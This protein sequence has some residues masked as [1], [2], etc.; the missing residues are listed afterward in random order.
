MNR[1]PD[2]SD[3]HSLTQGIEYCRVDYQKNLDADQT[4]NLRIQIFG[5]SRTHVQRSWEQVTEHAIVPTITDCLG[6]GWQ[7]IT[8]QQFSEWS[9]AY[10][11]RPQRSQDSHHNHTLKTKNPTLSV[12]NTLSQTASA[13]ATAGFIVGSVITLGNTVFGNRL[14]T[15]AKTHLTQSLAEADTTMVKALSTVMHG[16]FVQAPERLPDAFT[17]AIEVAE[18]AVLDGRIAESE[19]EWRDLARRWW[20]ASQLMA[21]IPSTDTRYAIAQDRIAFYQQNSAEA[22]LE[23]AQYSV[24]L[25]IDEQLN[26]FQQQVIRPDQHNPNTANS[27]TEQ[28]KTVDEKQGIGICQKPISEIIYP[29]LSPAQYKGSQWGIHIESLL[30]SDILYSYNSDKFFIPASNIK[31]FTTAAAFQMAQSQPTDDIQTLIRNAN[32][33]SNN[34]SAERLVQTMDGANKIKEILSKLGIDPHGYH[35]ADGSGL[36]R[37]NLATPKSLVEILRVMDETP[38]TEDYLNTLPVAGKRGTLH[39]RFHQTPAY[40]IVVAKTGTISG[41]RS[42]SG[43]LDHPLLGRLAFSILANHPHQSGY[44]LLEPIDDIIINLTQLE[45]CEG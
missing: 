21:E 3:R 29:I 14:D 28:L 42:L 33:H 32:L 10:Y 6:R 11:Q 23:T 35:Q 19:Q 15:S 7:L 37:K 44:V 2:P 30:T 20:E 5:R 17:Q 16:H 12:I 36:S 24:V 18:Q 9:V 8:A 40:G 27:N 26:T 45:S 34:W 31:L 25:P 13:W 43:Y 39:H 38:G 22:L 4:L 1:F 41:V